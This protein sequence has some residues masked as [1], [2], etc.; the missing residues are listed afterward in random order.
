MVVLLALQ[1]A[2]MELNRVI[3]HN[4]TSNAKGSAIWFRAGDLIIQN[5]L[6][7]DNYYSNSEGVGSAIALSGGR[8]INLLIILL[9]TIMVIQFG[10]LIKIRP[11]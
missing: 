8:Y 5:S 11:C 2:I 10:P 9:P 7:Y 1:D 3:L 4:N 6:F